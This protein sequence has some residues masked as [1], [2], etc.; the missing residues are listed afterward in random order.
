MKK[1]LIALITLSA[2]LSSCTKYNTP[3][4]YYEDYELPP[5]S[6][7][8]RKVLLLVVDGA[9]G[10]V[11][12]EV[13]PTTIAGILPQ[14]KYSFDALA[15]DHTSTPSSWTT[16]M[17]GV[18]TDLHGIEDA[19]YV[20]KPSGHNHHAS[21]EFVPS[22][23][24]RLKQARQSIN[25]LTFSRDLTMSNALMVDANTAEVLDSDTE[26]KN[27][28]VETLNTRNPEL[29]IA[30]FTDV[31]DAGL[32]SSF[33]AASTEYATAIQEV[34][35]HIGDILSALR[36]RENYEFEDWLVV[37]TSNH[38]GID[39]T[40][41]GDSYSERNTFAI[42]HQPD[43]VRAE[44]NASLMQS[45]RFWGHNST[46][47]PTGVRVVDAESG[48]DAF[49]SLANHRELTIEMKMSGRI[50]TV[51]WPGNFS[52]V[53]NYSYWYA[54]ILT[55]KSGVG[56]VAGWGFFT[57]NVNVSFSVS[58]GAQGVNVQTSRPD[59]DIWGVI[60][61]RVQEVGN[62]AALISI[63]NDGRLA[64]Q[65][66]L[67]NFNFANANS[68][69]QQFIIGFR[70]NISYELPD[71]DL[72]NVRFWNRALSDSEILQS[73][74]AYDLADGSTL[75]DGLLG[76]WRFLNVSANAVSNSVPD[77]R[78]LQFQANTPVSYRL[79]ANYSP[80]VDESSNAILLQ[81]VDVVT[82]TFYWFGIEPQQNWGLQGQVFLTNFELEF[83]R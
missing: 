25:I 2:A 75:L 80:C 51:E 52:G 39:N 16:L 73:T 64:A 19:S 68:A 69:A 33:S 5:D 46:N 71:F 44:L 67:Q 1:I 78:D 17:T 41:G 55:K 65:E 7:K 8:V 34:D 42:Y 28:V 48:S 40:H 29:V 12:E 56:N 35:S 13:M 4:P 45:V 37:I 14:S 43:F 77:S 26:V 66:E 10:R 24:F 57:W 18:N 54:P 72:S 50:K 81:S 32:A 6:T 21:T 82:Q 36:E 63:Y 9:V 23:I 58:D 70:D 31:L 53:G 83:I 62:G 76:D 79:A 11:V 20:P 74:C 27:K 15:D 59:G 30:Q 47:Q 61:G 60:T 49:F 22:F 3:A 38:G